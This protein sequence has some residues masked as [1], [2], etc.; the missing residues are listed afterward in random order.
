MHPAVPRQQE[1]QL[2]IQFN[3]KITTMP[4]IN[5]IDVEPGNLYAV[6]TWPNGHV[7]MFSRN[8]NE[9]DQL[10]YGPEWTWKEASD[11]Y[12]SLEHAMMAYADENPED[13]GN[14]VWL[15][16]FDRWLREQVKPFHPNEDDKDDWM[17]WELIMDEMPLSDL[18]YVQSISALKK[19]VVALEMAQRNEMDA[20]DVFFYLWMHKGRPYSRVIDEL[21]KKLSEL[22]PGK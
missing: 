1:N 12:P 5:G 14:H 6:A 11:Y 20:E 18:K 21:E 19:Y 13:T 7:K 17:C 4:K 15:T 3:T 22:N 2:I 16:P 10:D 9:D 8:Q